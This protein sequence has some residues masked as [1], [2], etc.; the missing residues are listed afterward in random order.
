MRV[1]RVVLTLVVSLMLASAV[2]A[3]ERKRGEGRRPGGAF[4]SEAIFKAVEALDLT[5]DQKEK[6]AALKDK[7][8]DLAK[9]REGLLTQEQ[10]DAR[11]KAMEDAKAAGKTGR[12][13]FE[14]AREAVKLTD[15]QRAKSEA[16]AKEGAALFKEL[17]GVLTDEQRT[18]LRESMR[19]RGERGERRK[20]Q[21]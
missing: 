15:E 2:T 1:A 14:A 21:N 20:P 3:A 8:A 7:A 4:L 10:K 9:K 6:V 18:K 17:M 5:A 16:L 19:P 12:E 13:I 11:Q